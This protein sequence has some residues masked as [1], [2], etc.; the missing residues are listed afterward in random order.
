MEA[1]RCNDSDFDF[2]VPVWVVKWENRK[3]AV[4]INQVLY[5]SKVV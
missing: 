1:D 5:V 3:S 2:T 4:V